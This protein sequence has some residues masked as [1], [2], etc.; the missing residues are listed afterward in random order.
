MFTS[1]KASLSDVGMAAENSIWDVFAYN[2]SHI[3]IEYA[4]ITADKMGI[5]RSY[6]YSMV[7]LSEWLDLENAQQL[8]ATNKDYAKSYRIAR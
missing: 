8:T 6:G 2:S 3:V 4:N 5:S 7:A 1:E